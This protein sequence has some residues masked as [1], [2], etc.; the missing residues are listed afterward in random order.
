MPLC[1]VLS[2][3]AKLG[4]HRLPGRWRRNG[5]TQQLHHAFHVHHQ[6][7]Q[8]RLRQDFGQAAVARSSR[9]VMPNHL[10]Q[11]AFD[12]RMRATRRL[13]LGR[14]RLGFDLFVFRFVIVLDDRSAARACRIFQA[15]GALR[16]ADALRRFELVTIARAL[17]RAAARSELMKL[18]ALRMPSMYSRMLCVCWSDTR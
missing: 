1:S 5:R 13:I 17:M 15:F 16:T 2:L 10:A 6:R 12:L 7:G 3:P 4:A 18:R 14:L 8:H 9:S 11:F